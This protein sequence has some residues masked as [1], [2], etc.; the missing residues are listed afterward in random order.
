MFHS[1]DLETSVG[2]CCIVL[3]SQEINHYLV[4]LNSLDTSIRMLL[5]WLLSK[6]IKLFVFFAVQR[7][8][9]L[10]YQPGSECFS[11]SLALF[12]FHHPLLLL[13]VYS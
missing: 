13:F 6:N 1:L 7:H 11:C 10:L 9:G 12:S 4:Y 3:K 5:N 2:E 8:T